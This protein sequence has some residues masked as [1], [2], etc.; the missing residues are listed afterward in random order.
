VRSGLAAGAVDDPVLCAT[1]GLRLALVLG[2]PLLANDTRRAVQVVQLSLRILQ[3]PQ[4]MSVVHLLYC[5]LLA[6][7]KNSKQRI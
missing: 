1:V 4:A 7:F 2:D 5:T 3:F 6:L